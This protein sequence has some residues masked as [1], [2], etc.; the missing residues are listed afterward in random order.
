MTEKSD[1]TQDDFYW[2]EKTFAYAEGK[3]ST[4]NCPGVGDI[5]KV[6]SFNPEKRRLIGEKCQ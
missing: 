1:T 5:E 2:L 4:Q 3:G 6:N